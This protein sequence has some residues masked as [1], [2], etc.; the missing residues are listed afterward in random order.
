MADLNKLFDES[1]DLNAVFDQ[2]SDVS[3]PVEEPGTLSDFLTATGQG[4][5]VGFGDEL[6]G[7]LSAGG[8]ALGGQTDLE[9]LYEIYRQSQKAN[10]AKVSEAQERSPIAS[11][12]GNLVGGAIPALATLGATAP[13]SAAAGG[14]TTMK[15]LSAL[16]W[17]QLLARAGTEGVKMGAKASI[18]AGIAALGASEHT[19]EQPLEL[20]K[21]TASGAAL[22]GV[23]GGGLG[24]IGTAGKGVLGKIANAADDFDVAR[25]GKLAFKHGEKGV[26]MTP[27]GEFFDTA[28]QQQRSDIAAITD[29][30]IHG[31]EKL[32][33]ELYDSL[34]GASQAGQ[35]VSVNPQVIGMI[36]TVNPQNPGLKDLVLGMSNRIGQQRA[37]NIA[38]QLELLEQGTIDPLKA[39]NLRKELYELAN[40]VPE[41]EGMLKGLGSSL[42]QD[43]EQAVPGI[44]QTA[45]ELQ[46]FI[47]A[48]KETLIEGGVAGRYS[49]RNASDV[50]N[51][52]K[53]L[54]DQVKGL[55][56][57]ITSSRG[58]MDWQRKFGELKDNLR[59]LD[60]M[61]LNK[62]G[63]NV[64][65]LDKQ[66]QSSADLFTIAKKLG[67]SELGAENFGDLTSVLSGG[68]VPTLR[69]GT[70]MAANKAGLAKRAMSEMTRDVYSWGKEPLTLLA[71]EL[72]SIPGL[73]HLGAALEK[74]LQDPTGA[75]KNSILFILM[76]RP[77]TRQMFSDMMGGTDT[78]K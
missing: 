43:I 71:Q 74:G 29:K 3:A 30:F 23:I 16:P 25:Q 45:S 55:L 9:K 36:Q 58:T 31:E 73:G 1:A 40:E 37:T 13:A 44:A 54:A 52:D 21:D 67:G 42:K 65:D 5:T 28:Q 68:M 50:F 63:I 62:L 69:G 56:E 15:T 24:A 49:Q 47:G 39:W 53:R 70:Y 11:I 20:A 51:V 57:N 75:S 60:P 38:H 12:A 2:A 66:V 76:Q 18:P 32:T 19:I 17:K 33:D 72:Q 41:L 27:S 34:R 78:T 14:A 4:L 77:D 61:L 10:E 46:D 8:A 22:G 48:G 59:K 26:S 6:G 7:A 35:K 64:D